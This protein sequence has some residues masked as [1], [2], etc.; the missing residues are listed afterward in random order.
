MNT[1]VKPWALVTGASSGLGAELARALARRSF[2]VILAARR[3]DPMQQLAAELKASHG[4]DVAV[5]SIDLGEPNSAGALIRQLDARG[6]QPE[7]LINNAAFGHS[8]L[9]TEQEPDRLRAMLQLDVTTLT[10]LTHTYARRMSA[11]GRGHILMVASIAAYQADPLL[12]VYGAAKAYVLSLG[13]ALH[14][15]LGPKVGVTVLCPGI[16][17]TEFFAVADYH[18]SE[19]LLRGATLP[20]TVAEAGI[21]AMFQK[22]PTITVGR[23]NRVSVMGS[24]LTPRMLAAR[25]AYRLGATSRAASKA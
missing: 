23:W 15:E 18:P 1:T 7:I 10:E 24:K 6:L 21:Q 8:G 5:E 17:Q 3:R 20:A 19:L 4:I 9:F 13:E 16:M 12:A 2:P 22:K 25:M 14:V 11:A